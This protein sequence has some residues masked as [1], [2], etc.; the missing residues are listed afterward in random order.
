MTNYSS[1]VPRT[2]SLVREPRD[3]SCAVTS[4]QDAAIRI[5]ENGAVTWSERWYYGGDGTPMAEWHQR[6]LRF[7]IANAR[8]GK[9]KIDTARLKADLRNG[10]LADLIDRIIA[11]HSIVWNG[12]NH[13]GRF[14]QDA[15]DAADDLRDH[16]ENRYTLSL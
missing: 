9:Q 7:E 13:V 3:T 8:H 12:S 4:Y 6:D 5:D 14:T 15:T 1:I 10:V 11:G 2:R 16:L